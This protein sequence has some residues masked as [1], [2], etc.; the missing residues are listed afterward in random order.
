MRQIESTDFEASNIEYIEFWLMDPFTEDP[1]NTGE[2]YI[3]LGEV[4]ED[5]LR[6]GRKSYENGL[7]ASEVIENV[8]TTAWGRVPTLQALVESFNISGA[9]RIHQDV[10]YDGLSTE[11]E[12][13]FYN[14]S[15]LDIIRQEYGANSVAYTNAINDPSADNYHYFRGGDYDNE[16]KYSS[17]LERYKNFN[18]SE[19]NSPTDDINPESYPTAATNYPDVE[20]INRDNTLS[21]SE[22]YFQYKILL[23]RNKMKVGEN[24]ITDVFEGTVE[25]KLPNGEE[26]HKTYWYQF[27]I[28]V[29]SPDKVIGS[30][31]DFR[32]VRFMRVFM[33]GFERPIV[34]RFAT[35][36]LVRGEWR[37]YDQVIRGPGVYP[38]GGTGNVG[39]FTVST[40][41]IEE[42][43]ERTPINYV[44]PPGID[45]ELTF[46]TTA[47]Y[48][49]N[50]QSLELKVSN[51]EDGY[52]SAVYKTTDFDF[53][54]YK[55]IKMYVHA[56]KMM[57]A[58]NLSFGDLTAFIRIG[59]DFTNNYYEYEVPLEFTRWY[60]NS[61]DSVWPEANNFEIILDELVNV[62]HNRNVAMR[63]PGSD[64]SLSKPYVEYIGNRKVTVFGSPS[65]SDVKGIMLGVRNPKQNL[66]QADDGNPESAIIWFDELRLTDF[67]DM[68]GWAAT[69]R[70]E[71]NLADLG[72]ITVSGS[73]SSAGFAS[74][75]TKISQIPL[76]ATTNFMVSTDLDL[77]KFA[78]EKAG[79]RL[80]MHYDYAVQEITP[81]YNPLDPD[82]KL[83]D[84]L[85]SYTSKS[86]RDSLEALV[87]DHTTNQ[88]INFMNV[89]KDRVD[90]KKKPRIYDV[91]N[92]DV[93]FAYSKFRHRNIDFEY[94]NQ[95]QYRGGFG[96]NFNPKPKNYQP[97]NS[98]KFLANARH[99]ALIKDF[100][101][102][103]LPKVLSFRTDMDRNIRKVLYRDKSLGD[104]IIKPTI[105]RQWNWNRT[106]DLKF[107]LSKSLALEFNAGANAF[108]NEPT[109][110]PDKGTPEWDA[111]KRA[112]W[113]SI[114]S[115]GTMN[116]Y[117]QSF[118]VTYNVPLKKIPE[119]DWVSMAL[120]YQALYNWAG[121]STS[122]RARFG[123]SIENSNQK[124]LNG[125]LD[126]STLYNKV[127]YIKNLNKTSRRSP[128]PA[129]RIRGGGPQPPAQAEDTTKPSVNVPKIIGDGL[130]KFLT[131]ITKANVTYSQ[132]NGMLLPGFKY[133]PELMGVN[134]AASAPTMGF[135]FGDQRDIRW[136]AANN[137]WLTT[138]PA[139]NNAY[140]TKF[141]ESL[142]YKVNGELFG[143]ISITI[144]GDRIY[145]ENSQ[146][147]FRYDTTINDFSISALTRTGN[148]NISYLAINTAFDKSNGKEVSQV[149]LDFLATRRTVADKL[150]HENPDW[151]LNQEYYYDTLAREEFPVGY[152][153][154][155]QSVLYY[156]FLSAYSGKSGSKIKTGTPFPSIPLPNWLITFNGLTKLNFIG[157]LFRTVNINHGYRSMLTVASWSSNMNYDPANPGK[158]QESSSNYVPEY[159]IGIVSISEQFSPLIGMDVTMHNSMSAKFALKKSRKLDLSFVNNQLTEVVGNEVT[160]GLGY[161]IKNL[162]FSIGSM[163]G[164]APSKKYSSDLNLKLDFSII[165]NITTLRRI[166]EVNNQISAGS[167]QYTLDFSGDYML[168]Q[169]VQLRLYYNWTSSKPY[170]SSQ[171]PNATTRGGFSL[172]FNLAQ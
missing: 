145:A 75:D 156:S 89:R 9:S 146:S 7:P 172:R 8:D 49:Q 52:A 28:P 43:G 164:T 112:I 124:Q 97:F 160:I 127:P 41:S 137:G 18:Q 133:E 77:G 54:Q 166:D 120:S 26:N 56:E 169:S 39:D 92:F 44:T 152:G 76:E 40:V 67:N 122:T 147:Y 84:D 106:Y 98:V 58:D 31:S 93:S 91:E 116:R 119:L 16:A 10:G 27:K 60:Q 17:V 115:F 113:D 12:K 57:E 72:R 99:L 4:S 51:L 136:D 6:D 154:N 55:R 20:D 82:I 32:S 63:Q 61:Q 148:F 37:R 131:S 68:N 111:Y 24:Y 45:R 170:V 69:G 78:G 102:Y 125:N 107:D 64:L 132:T 94:D 159:D 114:A 62:K 59:S 134:L 157:K 53:R 71:A 108:I 123:N 128:G 171:M 129:S 139:F 104:I 121:S 161:R 138:D 117:N 66:H 86:K 100:N 130:L 2:L 168:S 87:V 151:M 1:D 42:N 105:E 15:Y 65:I 90:T 74:L 110:Y 13:S 96:Y 109:I 35:F 14:S 11:D 155:S 19:G 143:A 150:A 79:L 22:R 135:V 126:L 80:P 81:E 3:N 29:H 38:S 118:R 85:D 162:K 73:H 101:F 70:I 5:I 141:T 36:E 144:N 50:E 23:D 25:G 21:E 103:L 95:D 46:G 48:Q 83:K 34:A 88:N 165:N 153:S 30:I 47:N 167:R 142:S 149:F 33:R 140:M 158:R 163:S